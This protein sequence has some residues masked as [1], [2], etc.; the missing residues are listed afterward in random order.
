MSDPIRISST[1]LRTAEADSIVLRVGA[2]NRL[3]FHPTLVENAADPD[4]GVRGVFTYQRKGR[5]DEWE[6]FHDL[7]LSQLKKGDSVQLELRSG[8]LLKLFRRLGPLYEIVR[9][10]GVPIG[11]HEFVAVAPGFW[12]A[13]IEDPVLRDATFTSEEFAAIHSFARWVADEPAKAAFALQALGSADLDAVNAVAGLARL[14]HYLD[15]WSSHRGETDEAFWQGLLAKESWVLGNLFGSPFVIMKERAYVGGKTFENT[16][17]RIA[18]F[19]FKN[20]ISGNVLLVEIKTPSTPL[21]AASPYRAGIYPATPELVGA[22]TQALDQR[23]TLIQNFHSLDLAGAG[24]APFSPRVVVLA[25]DIEK[26]S[27]SGPALRSFELFRGE[28]R[29]VEV[30]TF[31]ELANKTQA[32]IELFESAS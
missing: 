4:A 19:L 27:L 25:G 11:D 32:F 23:Q 17:G 20:A 12:R 26:Q 13:L 2:T 31:D 5:N 7:N 6:D 24:A 15:E 3:V 14:R 29:G 9:E 1:S 28:L 8:E 18:D 16:E 22:V 10:N 30:V 21:V